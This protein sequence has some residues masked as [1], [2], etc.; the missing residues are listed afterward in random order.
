VTGAFCK[1]FGQ[2]FEDL[3]RIVKERTDAAEAKISTIASSQKKENIEVVFD[4]YPI[5]KFTKNIG[6][7]DDD[8]WNAIVE[9]VE[10]V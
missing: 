5:L 3:Y 2:R 9:Y 10:A 8:L 4:R 6:S 7:K 1:E